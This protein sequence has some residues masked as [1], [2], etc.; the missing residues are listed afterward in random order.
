MISR[1][2]AESRK[3]VVKAPPISLSLAAIN[4][5]S[6]Q[7]AFLIPELTRAPQTHIHI[8]SFS[9][10][11]SELVVVLKPT[12]ES[13]NAENSQHDLQLDARQRCIKGSERI[14]IAVSL[15]Q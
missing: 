5:N 12:D 3:T 2:H 9:L 14:T 15:L 4:Q 6:P 13:V 8:A 10:G 11:V 7:V 1:S